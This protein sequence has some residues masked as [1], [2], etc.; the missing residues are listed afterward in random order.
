MK[1]GQSNALALSETFCLL[2]QALGRQL[3][4]LQTAGLIESIKFI[5]GSGLP[6][7]IWQLTFQGLNGFSDR[8]GIEG[9]AIEQIRSIEQNLTTNMISKLL[10]RQA[11]QKSIAYREKIGSG[12]VK[13]VLKNSSR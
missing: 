6:S 5:A 9:F 2:V 7:C 4:N 10:N 13:F 1:K 11:L 8:K 12:E 3:S